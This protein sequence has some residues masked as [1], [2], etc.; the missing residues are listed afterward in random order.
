[1]IAL[2]AV[3]LLPVAKGEASGKVPKDFFGIAQWDAPDVKDAQQMHAIKVRTVR[4]FFNWRAIE[5]RQGLYKWPDHLVAM[6]AENGIRPA[7]TV[8]TAPQW[9]TGSPNPGSPP[10]DGKG[11]R[12]HGRSS[13]RTRFGATGPT[14]PFGAT[15]PVCRVSR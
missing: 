4:L 13:S 15:T 5:P 11:A 9:A 1:M 6:L 3:A 2:A 14:G 8:Q 10:V 7:F 12:G